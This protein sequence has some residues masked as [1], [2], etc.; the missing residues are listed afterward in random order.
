MLRR[1]KVVLCREGGISQ[2]FLVLL[3]C[4]FESALHPAVAF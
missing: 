3:L 1:V 2:R 4:E